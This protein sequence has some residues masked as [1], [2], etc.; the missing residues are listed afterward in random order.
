MKQFIHR[1]YVVCLLALLVLPVVAQ[2]FINVSLEGAQTVC[3]ITQDAQGM[4][5]VGT[6]NG[7]YSYDGYHGYRHNQDHSY[8]NTR[9]N[10]LAF[11]NNLLYLATGNGILKFDTHANAYLQTPAVADF[12]NEVKRKAMKEL[13]VLDLQTR[14][15]NYGD[16]VY[17]LLH[18][19]KGLLQGKNQ[20]IV[21]EQSIIASF[22]WCSA[23]G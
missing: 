23:I 1:V 14:N 15:A 2:R 13:R 6:D 5:W 7:L 18:T 17:A 21:F 4:M 8:S 20:W 19:S 9:V 12:Q 10:A 16:D 22:C 11:D 3:S